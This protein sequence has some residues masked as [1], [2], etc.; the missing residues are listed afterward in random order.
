MYCTGFGDCFLLAFPGRDETPVYVWIDCGALPHASIPGGAREW[1][2]KIMQ[3]IKDTVGPAGVQLL[4]VTHKH[5]D[6][7]SGFYDGRE[8]FETIPVAEV[9]MPWTDNPEDKK[10]MA[11]VARETTLVRVA[12]KSAARMSEMRGHGDLRL[13]GMS[14]ALNAVLEFSGGL[15][16]VGVSTDAMQDIVR[17]RKTPQYLKPSLTPRI[18]SKAPDLRIHVLG[19]PE[20]AKFLK[21]MDPSG[22]GGREIYFGGVSIDA[23]QA[24]GAALAEDKAAPLS[25]EE[26]E[27]A[28]LSFPFPPELRRPAKELSKRA[29]TAGGTPGGLTHLHA[30]YYGAATDPKYNWRHID[31]NWLYAAAAMAIK[32]DNFR[33]NTSLAL[34]FELGEGGPVMLFPGDA[35]VGNWLSWH[36]RTDGTGP[37]ARDL[38]NRTVLYKAGHHGSENATLKEFGLELMAKHVDVSRGRLVALVPTSHTVAKSKTSKKNPEGWDIPWASL[39]RRLNELAGGRVVRIDEAAEWH[40]RLQQEA[41]PPGVEAEGWE[42]FKDNL[43][44]VMDP[45]TSAPLYVEIAVPKQH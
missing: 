44:V 10:A 2:T 21:K 6:H 24:L 34:A 20:D 17:G 12:L 9:W 5:L 41:V 29:S 3:S 33:N 30:T 18:L 43:K 8:V 19:P 15:A 42:W 37:S 45:S 25:D 14:E 32:A 11:L 28:R 4:V 36:Q 23:P 13:D 27:Q 7:L 35:Q 31:N 22:A 38:L 26:F 40:Q 1:F 16:A 39:M